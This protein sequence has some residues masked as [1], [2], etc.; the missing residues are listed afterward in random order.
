MNQIIE[1]R[2]RIRVI[3]KNWMGRLQNPHDDLS[4]YFRMCFFQIE[5]GI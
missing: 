1:S 4:G 3:H 2:Y 5:K